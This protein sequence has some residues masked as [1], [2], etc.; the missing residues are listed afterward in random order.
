MHFWGMFIWNISK[1]SRATI[2]YHSAKEEG[3]Y[4]ILFGTWN[5]KIGPLA[6]LQHSKKYFSVNLFYNFMGFVGS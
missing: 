6:F 4:R 2:K 5:E 1:I 3:I